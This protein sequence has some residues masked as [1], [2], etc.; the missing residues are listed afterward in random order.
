M[1]AISPNEWNNAWRDIGNSLP[2]PQTILS[3][4]AHWLTHNGLL[5]TSS[6]HPSMTYDM[7]GFPRE[8]YQQQYPAPGNPALAEEIQTA[9]Q[10]KI[11]S[12]RLRV[13]L[14]PRNLGCLETY[15][16]QS[17]HP[18]IQLSID[19]RKPPAFR[20]TGEAQPLRNR[21]C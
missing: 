4:S 10:L 6:E 5:V 17:R 20:T 12:Q 18:V 16:S 15:V 19:Y 9:L 13:G 1:N 3:I 14:R 2:K 11:P 21:A 8:L 7:G